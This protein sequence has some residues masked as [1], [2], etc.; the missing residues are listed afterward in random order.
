MLRLRITVGFCW[1][2][3]SQRMG[4]FTKIY[5][6][7]MSF[8][9][10]LPNFPAVKVSLRALHRNFRSTVQY[11]YFAAKPLIRIFAIK[12]SQITSNEANFHL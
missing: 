3:F 4:R 7:N 2:I 10:N 1:I 9:T 6:A 8:A 12:I 11:V 5:F